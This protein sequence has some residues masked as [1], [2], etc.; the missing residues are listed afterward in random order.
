MVNLEIRGLGVVIAPGS[1]VIIPLGRTTVRL[2]LDT[3]DRCSAIC[4][5]S[6]SLLVC[7]KVTLS[8]GPEG[9][10]EALRQLT[11]DSD[12]NLVRG[13]VL[14]GVVHHRH[15]RGGTKEGGNG[16]KQVYVEGLSR[17]KSPC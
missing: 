11:G 7:C 4:G 8:D 3:A 2:D 12:E 14:G 6:R 10:L 9:A 1:K 17:W 16:E 13:D 15:G 5:V